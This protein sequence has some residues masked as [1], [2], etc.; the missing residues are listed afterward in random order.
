MACYD[1]DSFRNKIFNKG[2]L[3]PADYDEHLLSKAKE[4]DTA[5]LKISLKWL[6]KKI[7]GQTG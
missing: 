2:L 7:F 5:L 3:N 4:D 1:I 6:Q